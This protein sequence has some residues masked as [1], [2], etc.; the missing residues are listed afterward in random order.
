MASVQ[1]TYEMEKRTDEALALIE[2]V[3]NE[4]V[5][6]DDCSSVDVFEQCERELLANAESFGLENDEQTRR[7]ANFISISTNF[8]SSTF[9]KRIQKVPTLIKSIQILLGEMRREIK[10]FNQ[11]ADQF[12]TLVKFFCD[13]V[14]DTKMNTSLV[15]PKMLAASD[16]IHI[17]ADVL[18]SNDTNRPLSDDDKQDAYLALTALATGV[19]KMLEFANVT[20]NQSKELRNRIETLKRNV[21]ERREVANSRISLAD[22]FR[23]LAPVGTGTAAAST[24]CTMIASAEFG[25]AGALVIAG[26]VLNPVSAVVLATLIGGGAVL[27]IASLVHYFWTKHQK[28][29]IGFLDQICKQIIELQ[30]TNA[31]FYECLSNN[32]TEVNNLIEQLDQILH[33]ITS[34]SQR[35]RNRNAVVCRRTLEAIGKTIESIENIK[36]INI[37]NWLDTENLPRFLERSLSLSLT[38][39]DHRML[40][41][42]NIERK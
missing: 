37:S 31:Y 10:E 28:K 25:G 3:T 7:F 22:T 1:D 21:K 16:H 32:E 5:E 4:V 34:D 9:T 8:A 40:C 6:H 20:K 13:L 15:L 19:K 24:L 14:D 42:S 11:V 30:R 36:K 38:E 35:F 41:S 17:L 18:E 39:K 33:S 26:A 29:A 2:R 12:E 27:G 23:F